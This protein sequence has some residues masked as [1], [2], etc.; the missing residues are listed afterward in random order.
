MEFIISYSFISSVKSIFWEAK[1]YFKRSN[2]FA[3]LCSIKYIFVDITQQ[4][5]SCINSLTIHSVFS[6]SKTVSHKFSQS[7]SL[8]NFCVSKNK[9]SFVIYVFPLF[10]ADCFKT[11][12]TPALTLNKLFC[13]IPSF[14]AILSADKNPIP[15][16]SST[17]LYGLVFKISS[18]LSKYVLYIFIASPVLML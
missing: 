1:S 5:S 14:W 13:G 7:S 9:L 12:I 18:V 2:F 15:S 3:M 8:S 10:S 16:T 4:V 17:S 6:S 11:Y